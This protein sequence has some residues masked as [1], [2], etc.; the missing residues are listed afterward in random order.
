M[1]NSDMK[2]SDKLLFDEIFA[3]KKRLADLERSVFAYLRAPVPAHGKPEETK[4]KAEDY[5]VE[6][7][8]G[9]VCLNCKHIVL[10]VFQ[11]QG[12]I[13]IPFHALYTGYISWK[14]RSRC[15]PN[16]SLGGNPPH[17]VIITHILCAVIMY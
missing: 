1:Q 15:N 2:D 6:V 17:T 3:L 9:T 10:K 12:A 16:A 5:D 7:I 13:N 8:S 14:F 4:N 11:S